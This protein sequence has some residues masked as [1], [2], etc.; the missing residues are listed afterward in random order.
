[1]NYFEF[2]QNNARWLL[3]GALLT[4][5]ST[6]GQTYFIALFGGEIRE[7]FSL[8]HG[9]F[10]FVYMMATLAS[11]LTLIQLGQLADKMRLKTLGLASIVGL[12]IA[13]FAMSLS[14]SWT[15]LLLGL[16]LLRLLGQAMMS[17][18][19]MTAM[20][21]WFNAHRG[22][23]LGIASLGH[24]AGEAVMPGLAVFAMTLT[25]WR[26]TWALAGLVLIG[27]IAPV[28][29]WLTRKERPVG[30]AVE[31]HEAE[32]GIGHWTR[33]QVVRDRLF[34]ALLP[35]TLAPAFIVTV[36]FF[37]QAFLI[38]TK[39]WSMVVWAGFFPL[40]AGAATVVALLTG[41]AVDRW[42]ARRVLPFYLLPIA[43]AMAVFA[44]GQSLYAAMAGM[45]LIGCTVGAAQTVSS[46]IWAELY[47]TRHLGSIK[48]LTAAGAVLSTAVGP[49]LTGL[50]L[51]AGVA[52][53]KLLLAMGVYCVFMSVMFLMLVPRLMVVRKP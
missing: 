24:S 12:T 5:A 3:A 21:R 31:Q 20:A 7:V 44:Y 33:A 10:G 11:A 40:F 22:R 47:G 52:L 37:H 50:L 39:G 6:F 8:S 15:V 41:W 45:V 51:D 43:M 1:M 32:T 16:Y 34:Y 29:Y 27:V 42:S 30:Q 23:A 48:A 38:E 4:L 35:G 46:A 2:L 28:F 14:T 19:A 25:D 36:T 17:H 18:I 53:S 26:N 9:Q 49:G 13:C